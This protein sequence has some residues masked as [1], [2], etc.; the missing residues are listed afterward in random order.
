MGEVTGLVPLIDEVV[1]RLPRARV[2]VSTT[3]LTGRDRARELLRESATVFLLPWEL[4]WSIHRV[5]KPLAP[6]LL[7]LSET[8]LWP[9]LIRITRSLGVTPVLVNARLTRKAFRRYRSFGFLFRRVVGQLSYCAC[10]TE[11]D[12]RRYRRLGLPESVSVLTG[13]TK[14]D[15][16]VTG[17]EEPISRDELG[18]NPDDILLVAGS[19]R[20][21]EEELVLKSFLGLRSEF[22]S[23]RLVVVPRHLDRLPEV[24]N[25]LDQLGLNF[26]LR[27]RAGRLDREPVLLVDRMGEL[28][29]LYRLADVGLVGGGFGPFGGHNPLE[30]ARSGIPVIYGPNMQNQSAYVAALSAGGG[31]FAVSDSEELAALL[32]RFLT[33][34]DFRRRSGASAAESVRSL[35]GVA[36]ALVDDWMKFGFLP[37]ASGKD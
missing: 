35:S 5:L 26:G 32:R 9:N 8:E 36:A 20:P 29:D 23:L 12:L 18:L 1:E 10:Q 13:S 14:A 19:T 22:P 27:S 28:I 33:D 15:F 2:A 7:V 30:P 11:E 37:S 25:L 6:H 21:G 3:S 24:E 4:G 34:P 16:I 31:G 17:E